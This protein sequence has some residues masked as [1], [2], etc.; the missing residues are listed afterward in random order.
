[1]KT[2]GRHFGGVRK[3]VKTQELIVQRESKVES[4]RLKEEAAAVGVRQSQW[5]RAREREC[6][7][8]VAEGSASYFTIYFT[9][10]VKSGPLRSVA[11][12]GPEKQARI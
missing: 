5:T 3:S 10:Q 8:S 12:A 2:L 9:I 1:M 11:S 7:A 6:V 4:S